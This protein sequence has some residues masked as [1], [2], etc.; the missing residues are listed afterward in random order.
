MPRASVIS[1]CVLF[2]ALGGCAHDFTEAEVESV[3]TP[4]WQPQWTGY[5]EAATFRHSPELLT[6]APK[7]LEEITTF[8]PG[9]RSASR[10]ER[11]QF[12]AAFFASV[13]R[14]E[15]NFDPA[16]RMREAW[17]D[18]D[19]GAPQQSEGLLQLSYSDRNYHPDC[20]L[21]RAL[22]NILD[23]EVN[24]SCGVAI[25]RRQLAARGTLFPRPKPYYW[26]VLT[27]KQVQP[28]L[29]RDLSTRAAALA[30]CPA[31]PSL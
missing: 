25:L 16:A 12:W 11:A 28:R 14:Y 26:A 10:S 2:V 13:A 27:S 17:N 6:P 8:C 15:S 4:A 24:L 20:A 22:G 29:K 19:T 5:V 31:K 18:P 23:P 7:P 21:D 9:F 3:K 30:F 1:T